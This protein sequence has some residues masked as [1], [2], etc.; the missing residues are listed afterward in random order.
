M[1]QAVLLR[2][3]AGLVSFRGEPIPYAL[4][5]SLY[6]WFVECCRRA[7]EAGDFDTQTS[8]FL[9]SQELFAALCRADRLALAA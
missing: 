8:A 2:A 7:R 4:A 5:E 6:D 1:M 9:A 3:H